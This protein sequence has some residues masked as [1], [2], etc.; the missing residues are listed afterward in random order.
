MVYAAAQPTALHELKDLAY[1]MISRPDDGILD[2]QYLSTIWK[3]HQ[4]GSFD[5]SAYLWSVFSV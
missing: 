5:R 2:R 4:S 3:Q 1:Y